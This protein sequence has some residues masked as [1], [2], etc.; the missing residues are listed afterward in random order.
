VSLSESISLAWEAAQCPGAA[1]AYI[2]DGQISIV[3]IGTRDI[4]TR[5]PITDRT[6]F[7]AAS[8]TKPIISYAVLQLVDQGILDLDVPLSNFTTSIISNN[9]L[10]SKITVRHILTHTSGLPNLKENESI[11]VYF[12]PGTRYSYSSIGFM[13]LQKALEV[14]INES[15]ESTIRRMV[16]EPLCMTQS[17]LIWNDRFEKNIATPHENGE[18]LEKHRPL[19]PNASYSLQTTAADYGRFVAAVLQG[20][21]LKPKTYD[22][23]LRPAVNAPKESSSQLQD[24]SAIISKE[25]AW[26]LGWGLEPG[27]STFFQWGKMNGIRAFV[28]GSKNLNSGIVLLTNGNTGLRLVDSAIKSFSPIYHPSVQWLENCVTE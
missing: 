24:A 8:L 15:L 27:C 26:G 9:P 22:E 17:S 13:F 5:Q 7:D 12:E 23:W 2:S 1:I 28:M 25:I 10:F 19:Q 21:R 14:L 3:N 18:R 6:V 11:Q 20:I 16:F 4:A